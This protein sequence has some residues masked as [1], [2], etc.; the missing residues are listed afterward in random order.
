MFYDVR[1]GMDKLKF[2]LTAPTL[3]IAMYSRIIF[4]HIMMVVCKKIFSINE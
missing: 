4:K 2:M 1:I 3:N